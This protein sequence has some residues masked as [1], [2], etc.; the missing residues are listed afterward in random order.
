MEPIRLRRCLIIKLKLC[1]LG[2]SFESLVKLAWADFYTG[3]VGRGRVDFGLS[4]PAPV[5]ADHASE[6]VLKKVILWK[7]RMH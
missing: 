3:R 7:Q 5:T 1:C 6:N 4:C 2:P